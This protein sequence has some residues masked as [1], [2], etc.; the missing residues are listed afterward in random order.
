MHNKVWHVL[1]LCTNNA[2]RS[3]LA[4]SL[5]NRLGQGAF[6]AYSAGSE[7]TGHFIHLPFATLDRVTLQ[8][9]LA[10]IGKESDPWR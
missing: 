3:I 7:P 1:F 5:L 9:R 4:E 2:V 10:A 8:R 6:Q